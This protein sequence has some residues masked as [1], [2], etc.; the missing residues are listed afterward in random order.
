MSPFDAEQ[1]S[2]DTFYDLKK[3]ELNSLAKHLKLEIKKEM[4]KHQI[5]NIIVEHLVS[6]KVFEEPVLETVKTSD[7]ALK[8]LQ[9]QLEFK[10]LEMEERL[11][12]EDRE[13]Q[14]RLEEKERQ[15]RLEREEKERQ[16]R[17]EEKERQERLEKEKMQLQ[18]EFEMRKLELQVKLGSDLSVEKS[19]AKFDVSKHISLCHH[20]NRQRLTSIFLHFEKVAGNRNW[21]K[22]Y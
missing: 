21:P 11:E 15:E 20:F 19:S 6:L 18:P 22:A 14:E 9:L 4:R 5:Q 3:D 1:F 2:E 7:S 13:R 12:M 17:R 10:K 16:E 8:K